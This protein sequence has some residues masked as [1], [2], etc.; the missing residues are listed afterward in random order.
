MLNLESALVIELKDA[1]TWGSALRP[2]DS[3]E[4]TTVDPAAALDI[5]AYARRDRELAYRDVI[6]AYAVFK[7]AL[8]VAEVWHYSAAK[9]TLQG[10]PYTAQLPHIPG[11]ARNLDSVVYHVKNSSVPYDAARITD[12][13]LYG[14]DA[15]L[16]EVLARA[17]AVFENPPITRIDNSG[18][19]TP[20]VVWSK[21]EGVDVQVDASPSLPL[22]VDLFKKPDQYLAERDNQIA[23]YVSRLAEILKNPFE[24]AERL[25]VRIT[26]TDTR[27]A[28]VYVRTY[29][30][31]KTGVIYGLDDEVYYES[32]YY[33][34]NG[35]TTNVPVDDDVVDADW[36]EI[37]AP[38]KR[39]FVAE[40]VLDG[41]NQI[42][43]NTV[44]KTLQ[45]VREQSDSVHVPQLFALSVPGIFPGQS[46]QTLTRAPETKDAQFFAEKASR[47]VFEG[48]IG[49]HIVTPGQSNYNPSWLQTTATPSTSG[50]FIIQDEDEKAACLPV[51]GNMS[52]KFSGLSA[53]AGKYRVSA[54]ARPETDLVIPG[55]QNTSGIVSTGDGA[56]FPTL[57]ST[58][59]YTLALPPGAWTM[60][61]EYTNVS[62]TTKSFG[63]NVTYGSTSVFRDVLPLPFTDSAGDPLDNGTVMTSPEI[64]L[65]PDYAYKPLQFTWT[66]GSGQFH[67]RRILFTLADSEPGRYSLEATFCGKT[68]VMDVIGT[69]KQPEVMHFDFV[70]TGSNFEPVFTLKWTDGTALL[71]LVLPQAAVVHYAA[72]ST[73]FPYPVTPS[74]N[75]FEGIKQDYLERALRSVLD[76]YRKGI[77]SAAALPEFD[78]EGT[79]HATSTQMWMKFIRSYHERLYS[80]LVSEDSLISKGKEY[81]VAEGSGGAGIE[82]NGVTYRNGETFIGVEG[83]TAFTNL[84]TSSLLRT[85]AFRIGTPSD[86]GRP[87]LVPDGLEYDELTA[88]VKCH[89]DASKSLP[90]IQTF[91]PWMVEIGIHVA[92]ASFWATDIPLMSS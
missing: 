11:E 87:A 71:P 61:F 85:G 57:S 60:Q 65:T 3:G 37:S 83:E 88:T 28:E 58:I 5:T 66:Y 54:L 47:T 76:S 36:T 15:L 80:E 90:T 7:V 56:T 12:K 42:V 2:S 50:G 1:I 18:T 84:G 13:D 19:I 75:G 70:S 26:G 64:A 45:W 86:V 44:D 16:F 22:G 21:A 68:A 4:L 40:P 67:L 9:P 24:F 14:R 38:T 79:W 8:E 51:P 33:R 81:I 72:V 89:Y 31:W 46:I 34:A 20:S 41:R 49:Q 43:Y 29:P 69:K 27:Q 92:A 53:P 52:I 55:A 25:Y 82:Y 63:V 10:A 35:T 59:G 17:A 74:S 23:A 62:G 6:N 48:E 77:A 73:L 78:D 39:L 30:Y 91:Q 32:V